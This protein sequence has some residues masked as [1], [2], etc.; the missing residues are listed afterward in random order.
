MPTDTTSIPT[1]NGADAGPKARLLTLSDLD[2]RTM[3]FRKTNDLIR[4]YLK[5]ADCCR[6]DKNVE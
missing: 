3:A 2:R 4:T 5:I 6:S 1:G